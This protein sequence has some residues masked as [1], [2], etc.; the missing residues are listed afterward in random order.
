MHRLFRNAARIAALTVVIVGGGAVA[1]IP[2]AMADIGAEIG[3]VCSGKSG[4]HKVGLRIET[5]APS[6]GTVGQPIQLGT[7][8]I[9]VGVPA[10]LVTKVRAGSTGEPTTPPVTSVTPSAV[11]P[12]ALSGVAEIK[13]A[14]REIDRA[15]DGGWPAFALAATPSRGDGIVHLTGSG[16]APPVTPHSPGGLS[17]SAGEV[18]LSL[19]PAGTTTGRDGTETALHCVAEKDAVLGTVQVD[20][21][22]EAATPSSLS[23]APRQSTAAQAN[24]CEILPKPGVD[25]RYAI[26]YEDAAL[27]KIYESPPVPGNLRPTY[28]EGVPYCI[29]GLGFINA[30][31]TGN[32]VPVAIEASTQFVTETYQGNAII[33]PNYREFR[34]YAVNRTY[35]TPTTMLGFGFMPTSALAEAVQVGAPE[36]AEDDPITANVRLIQRAF[37]N[38]TLP[39]IATDQLRASSYVRIKAVEAQVNGVPLDLGGQCMTSSTAFVGKAFLG[40]WRTGMLA[41]TEGQTLV[42]DDLNIPAFSGCG[43]TE[44]LSPILTASVS[45]SGNYANLETGHWC[46]ANTGTNCVNDAGP[47]PPTFTV[48]P[49]GRTTA[50]AHPFVLTRDVSSPEPTQFR[51]ESATTRFQF[52]G[53]HWQSRFMLAKGDMSLEGCKVKASDGSEYPVVE[54]TQEGALWL[55]VYLFDKDPMELQ[56]TG[57][58]L[59]AG[60]DVDK[61]GTA[62]CSIQINQPRQRSIADRRLSGTAG[63]VQGPYS[64]GVLSMKYNTLGV[65][66]G[67]TCKIPGF[68]RTS[69]T[70]HLD[71]ADLEETKFAF[72]P[73]QRIAWD[74][75]H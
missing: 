73:A 60:V 75:G 44:D 58:M 9:D 55:G 6:S 42:V 30:K 52:K 54:T 65:A 62:D 47:L 21:A 38:Y 74:T 33:G 63:Q 53:A 49:G 1:T 16:V 71:F 26:N 29:K 36:G 41:Y 13:V 34:G 27:A 8:K 56:I 67:S 2:P 40:N 12:P 31:K 3:L 23:E 7:V 72:S 59:T 10:D 15:Q 46:T 18:G 69:P 68:E 51:C 17:W 4:T 43:V 35:P 50:T 11:T 24:L 48:D 20:P 64:N 32:A 25:P 57:V 22:S 37:E 14:I 66:P 61:N 45:G 39:P 28:R 70:E 19:V 5:T